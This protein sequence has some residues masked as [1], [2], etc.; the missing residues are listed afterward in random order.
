MKKIILS[1]IMITS[2]MACSQ[3]KNQVM[4]NQNITADNLVEEIA[5]QVKHYP[6]EKI[7]HLGY[8]NDKCYF[9]M[10]VDGVRVYKKSNKI[11]GNTAVEINHLLFKSGKHTVSYK[12]YPAGKVAE[13]HETFSAL[14]EDTQLEF[15]LT[16]YDLKKKEANDIEYMKYEV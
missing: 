1:T 5:K 11:L 7:Y 2:F 9:E 6:S 3:P 8:F 13:Y 10:F 12:M 4:Q 14:V 16:S 15:D